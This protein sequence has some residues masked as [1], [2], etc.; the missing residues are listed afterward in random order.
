MV[1]SDKKAGRPFS[2]NPKLVKLT[3]RIDNNEAEILDDYCERTKKKRADGIREAIRDLK[4][5]K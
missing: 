2:D 5:K 4:D 3:V 1:L